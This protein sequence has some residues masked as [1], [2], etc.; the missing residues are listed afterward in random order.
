MYVLLF[1]RLLMKLDIYQ[2]AY[3]VSSSGEGCSRNK[4]SALLSETFQ[5]L[6]ALS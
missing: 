6:G 3:G 4:D 2:R 1:L 5:G